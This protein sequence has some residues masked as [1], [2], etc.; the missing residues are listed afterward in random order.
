MFKALVDRMLRRSEIK[1]LPGP[2]QG[3]EAPTGDIY[4]F[5]TAPFNEF[6]PPDTGRYAAIKV[7]RVDTDQFVV[8]VLDGVWTTP[9]SFEEVSRA[10]VLMETRFGFDGSPAVFGVFRTWWDLADLQDV[11]LLGAKPLTL[12]EQ[13]FAAELN[14]Y[15]TLN[16]ANY[17]AEGEWRWKHDRQALE[18]EVA[19][20]AKR[21]A[22]K[23]EAAELRYRTRLSK[24][25]WDQ[26]LS[27]TPF[28]RWAPS[29]PFPP[30]VF[31]LEAR[32]TIHEACVTLRDLGPKPKKAA[33]RVVLR[34]V[35]EWFNK[36]DRDAGEVIETEERE[37]ICA[38]LEEMA[39]VARQKSLVDE[40]DAWREW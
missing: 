16:N 24:L 7:L 2:S 14:A 31:T 40:V 30:E 34:Q 6:G 26:L 5:R 38:V 35:V 11:T 22:A 17:A 29:P 32:R 4:R 18:A 21:E 27:E 23:R 19:E 9:P 10:D 25:T 13:R 37:D 8:A 3:V 1:A 33:V 36:A 12:A 39:F 20:N 15:T 28:E